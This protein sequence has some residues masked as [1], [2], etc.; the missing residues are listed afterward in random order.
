MNTRQFRFGEIEV[1]ASTRTV[2]RGGRIQSV[3]PKVFDVLVLL[4]THRDR[5]VTRH[6]LLDGV[7]GRQVVTEGVVTRTVMK[8]RRLIGDDGDPEFI[9]TQHRI[10]Y[11]FVAEVEERDAVL[12]DLAA[13]PQ[14]DAAPE[15]RI[16]VLPL[17]NDTGRPEL[18]WIDL[19]LMSTTRNHIAAQV[20]EPGV[21]PASELLAVVAGR[22]GAWD[23]ETLAARL[24]AALGPVDVLQAWLGRDAGG[25]LWLGYRGC[26]K[27]FEG[28]QGELSGTDAVQLSHQLAQ[29][30]C[31]RL[32][33]R[34]AIGPDGAAPACA[35][36]RFA[37]AARARAQKAMAEERWSV[38]RRLLRVALDQ[39][40]H[41]LALQLDH[42]RCL[43]GCHDPRAAGVLAEILQ[44]AH[45]S[46]R[47]ALELRA[48]H[49]LARHRH[50]CGEPAEAERLLTD[51]LRRAEAGG[52]AEAELQL[53]LSNA[54]ALVCHGQPAMASWMLDRAGVIAGRLGHP[55]ALARMPD[56]RGRIAVYRAEPELARQAFEEASRLHE[57]HGMNAGLAHALVHLGHCLRDAGRLGEAAG[58]FVRAFGH[59]LSSGNPGTIAVSG[60]CCIRYGASGADPDAVLAQMRS[61]A[62]VPGSV[63]FAEGLLLARRGRLQ[64]A[65]A[66]L[67]RA[68]QCMA[69]SPSLAFHLSVLRIR[70]L[71]CLGRLDEALDLCDQLR[72]RA[73][74]RLQRPM[75]GASLHLRALI[76]WAEGRPSVAAGLL[77]DGLHAY[78]PS[79]ARAEAVLD[80]ACVHRE[81]G[82]EAQARSLLDGIAPFLRA[83]LAEGHG[84][85][86]CLQDWRTGPRTLRAMPSLHEFLTAARF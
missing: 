86:R 81:L 36:E 78:P 16:A 65:V 63:E 79:I 57:L 82:Q 34:A 1:N 64:D 60:V 25:L 4:L 55:V 28:L 50:D 52:D 26:G 12:A 71:V 41:D 76:L 5:V 49:L 17:R 56:I 67:G 10:G 3:E 21:V 53:L 73:G 66:T 54:E 29:R 39:R 15:G 44:R 61:A 33:A 2:L 74:G 24:A 27:R 68:A 40:P 35:D 46:G 59:A 48:L 58:L 22:D 51:T 38:A 9:H 32:P 37:D 70:T 84:P 20:G 45:Q 14:A 6:E 72:A 11:R 47:Q 43:V 77:Q 62:A 18:G 7:W 30:A 13:P 75:L 85:S 69:G 80:A 23:L 19:G 8:A 42:A 31:E 83:A